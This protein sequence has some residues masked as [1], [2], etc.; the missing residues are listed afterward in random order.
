MKNTARRVTLAFLGIA[1]AFTAQAQG[2][3]K[4][5]KQA[6]AVCQACHGANGEGN[7]VLNAPRLSGQEDWY[8]A[9]QLQNFKAGIRGAHPKDTFGMQMRP[10][11]MTLPTDQAVQDVAAYT[12]TLKAP[13]AAP[14]MKGD[15]KAGKAAYAVCQACHGAN[16]EGNKVLN[17][18]RLAG[19]EDW[20]VVRQ[21]QNFKAG[22]RGAH[23]KDTFGMQMRPMAMTLANDAA[24]NNVAAYIATLKE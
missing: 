18:P 2:D 12:A 3:A 9:R 21:L 13:A 7:K 5:G 16:G 22:I 6:Y 4:R 8:V 14:T 19:Q 15:T 24:I 23:P 10:M 17:A 20:Y 1:L 11:A